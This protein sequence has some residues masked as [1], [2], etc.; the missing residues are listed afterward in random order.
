MPSFKTITAFLALM[1]VV[2]A[3]PIEL[4]KRGNG[5]DNGVDNSTSNSKSGGKKFSIKQVPGKKRAKNGANDILQTYQKYN[6]R[7]PRDVSSAAAATPAGTVKGSVAAN[8]EAWDVQYLSPVTVGQNEMQ[9]DFD[10]GSSD[11]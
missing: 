3:S 4:D 11:L 9:L 8:P 1:S 7:P 5:N 10:T 2:S 6:L